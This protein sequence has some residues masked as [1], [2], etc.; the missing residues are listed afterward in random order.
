MH[1]CELMGWFLA[2]GHTLD[3]DK[4]FGISQ[5]KEEQRGKI[6]RLLN[7]CGF[8]FR[9]SS[10]GFQVSSPKWWAY[11]KQFGKC[12]D[13]FVPREI[14][15]SLFL[16]YFFEALM[17]GDG[18]WES[19][20]SG[21]YYTIS[22]KLANDVM[23]VCVRLGYSTRLYKRQRGTRDGLSYEVRFSTRNVTELNTGNHLYEVETTNS[24][25]NC[26]KSYFKGKVYCITVPD[27][28]TFFIRQNGYV[29]V[30]GNTWVKK[31]FI[32]PSTPGKSFWARDL[33]GNLMVW[34]QNSKF[35]QE[36]DLVGKPM[37]KRRFI[38]ATLFDNPYL[39]EDGSYEANLLSLPE[40][41]RKQ[42]LEGSWDVAE[43]AAFAEWSR[44]LHVIEPFEIPRNW[45][46]FRA[47]DYGYGSFAAVLWFAVDPNSEQLIVYRELKVKKV[48][49]VDLADMI[50]EAEAGEK[51]RYGVL[52]SSLWHNRGDTGPSLAEQMI[53]RGCRW[54]PADRSRGS[55]VA[56]K[57]E[58]HRRLQVD[59]YTEQPRLVFF[60]TCLNS[61]SE[62]P[63][64]PL[65]KK[66]P[67]DVD[68]TVDDHIYDA[69][70]YGVQSRPTSNLF[71]FDDFSSRVEMP[72]S[73]SVFGY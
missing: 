33:D 30:S 25:V 37:F 22:E 24:K 44:N 70:R 66:N 72:I 47:C 53:R 58:V 18:H 71:D 21:T 26:E 17:D 63:I 42:L 23:E 50:L 12:R 29:W 67:E 9:E 73:D 35:A 4:E 36:N 56:S 54:R 34:P 48:L 52:D 62:L 14:M 51:I 28:E 43:G 11:F 46:R 60:N 49:A 38:P 39:S 55:R 1:Y 10:T 57:N 45:V 31:T 2:E 7:D 32:D 15:D 61:I 68:T 65:D 3:R 59:P 13:K 64:L 8:R 19:R 16:R 20:G 6:R 5:V 40:H 41:Q 69:L 27:T